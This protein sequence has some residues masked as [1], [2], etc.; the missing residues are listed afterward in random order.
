MFRKMPIILL[1]VILFAVF[2]G[3]LIP[4]PLKSML[5]ALSLSIK[6]T[7]VFALPMIIFM[8]LFKT[9]AGLARNATKMI[10]LILGAVCCSNFI[11]TMIS[12]QVGSAI[13]G[14]E[15]SI[16]LPKD[17]EGLAAAWSFRLPKWLANDHAMFSG[18]IFGILFS[19]FQPKLAEK[20]SAHFEKIVT[21]VLRGIIFIIPV[22]IFGFVIKLIHDR[23]L[24][25]IVQDYALIFSLVALAVFGYVFLIYLISNRFQCSSF[26]AS[27]KNM[28]PACIA[29]FGSM[30]SAASMPLTIIGTEKNTNDPNLTRLV[31]PSTV[32]VHL[33][34]DCFAIPIFAFAVM[35]NFGIAEPAFSSYLAFS[36]YFVM[37]KFSV[38][39]IPGGGIIVMLP[40]LESILGF[41]AEMCSLITALYILFDPVI[42]CANVAGNGGF[43]MLLNK[44]LKTQL[45]KR[46]N[47][48]DL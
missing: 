22:F 21:Q 24:Q 11:S 17:M 10:I 5:Y 12:Y 14:M 25:S 1:V 43:A 15:L 23:V 33:I 46:S 37:A 35:K 39:A 20:I 47:A 13:Y 27:L 32:N 42:T 2:C 9:M 4:V 16:A 36:F 48:I 19:L 29:G 44:L 34:G 18:V 45:K 26:S 28:L 3:G 31:I 7:I 30:S 40:I 38:A 41:N 8:L 6:S